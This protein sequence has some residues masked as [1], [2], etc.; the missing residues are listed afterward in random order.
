VVTLSGFLGFGTPL[1]YRLQ[2]Q[3]QRVRVRYPE[4]VSVTFNSTIALNGTSD[5]STVSGV[6]TLVRASFT[7]RADMSQMF[8]QAA[9]PIPTSASPGEYLRGMQFDVRIQSDPNFQLQTS[10][11]RN[12]QAE[13]DL[14][15]RGTP[16]RPA[17]LGTASVNEGEMEVFGN[18][19]TVNRGDIRFLNPVRIDP[20]F[21]LDMETKARGVTVNV[22]I[23]GTM[24]KM[25]VNYSSDPPLQPREIIA[26]LAVG[27]APTNSAGIGPDAASTSS[28][29]LSAAGGGLISEAISE[30][31]SSRFQRFFG[32]SRVK[33]D[34]AVPGVEYLPEARLTVE[35]QVSKDVTLTY[36]T[37]LNRTEEQI[38]Q[39]EWDFS[40][41]WSAVAVR[42]ANGLFG[43]DF[44]YR[45]RFK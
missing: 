35:Q 41:R 45:K 12:L 32:A 18:K 17:L 29:S 3:A 8:A 22:A 31:L 4:D 9:R 24:Q 25:N 28:T 11:A 14:R 44:I 16:L 26:L 33:I 27:R 10:L 38:V 7:P 40:K 2:A 13:V 34:P 1:V 43:V 23:A 20:I 42:D 15:L 37:N 36:I 6:I 21:D 19:Y 5:S 39:I 30:Q